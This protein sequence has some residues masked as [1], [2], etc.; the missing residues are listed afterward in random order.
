MRSSIFCFSFF[1]CL[2]VACTSTDNKLNYRDLMSYGVP[3]E[4][5]APDS[6][7]IRESDFG[8]QKDIVLQ[9]DDGY[10]I[11]I[12][13]STAYQNQAATVKN[14]KEEIASSPYFKEF[15][16]DED[17][18]FVYA[19]QLDSTTVNYGFRYIEVKGGKEIVIQQGML[20]FYTLEEAKKLFGYALRIK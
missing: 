4:I 19:F 18:G 6:V 1:F 13:Y 17:K 7:D 5:E 16:Q 11:Q 9:G 8:L 14:Y 2:I 15:V 3:I 10:N 12:F 20:G